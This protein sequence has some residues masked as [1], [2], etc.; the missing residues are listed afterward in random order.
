MTGVK[1]V[2]RWVDLWADQM[3]SSTVETMADT[4]DA[5]SAA[6]SAVYLVASM[7]DQWVAC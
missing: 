4:M 1:K 6:R 3:A 2:V 5:C 7:A